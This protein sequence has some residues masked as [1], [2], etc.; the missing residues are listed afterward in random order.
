MLISVG[1]LVKIIVLAR[2][3]QPPIDPPRHPIKEN[4]RMAMPGDRRA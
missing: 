1:P 2:L 4:A 3:L